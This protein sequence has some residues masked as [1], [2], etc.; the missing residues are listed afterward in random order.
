MRLSK[1]SLSITTPF[2]LATG[3]L[4]A[5]VAEF[6]LIDWILWAIM[7][8]VVTI[9]ASTIIDTQIEIL[10]KFTKDKTASQN[11]TDDAQ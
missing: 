10:K 11:E 7:A 3:I 8:I 5:I 2:V 1:L 9:G 4:F 6:S